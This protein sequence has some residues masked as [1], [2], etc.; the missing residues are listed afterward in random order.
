MQRVCHMLY[1]VVVLEI[2]RL[3]ELAL[4]TV[5]ALLMILKRASKV[6]NADNDSQGCTAFQNKRSGR[7]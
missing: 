3:D 1:A 5:A 4:I 2:S 7:P 6:E